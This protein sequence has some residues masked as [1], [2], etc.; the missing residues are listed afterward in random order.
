M[1]P[2]RGK[3]T[4]RFDP[5]SMLTE[6]IFNIETGAVAYVAVRLH[7]GRRPDAF[8]METYEEIESGSD[9]RITFTEARPLCQ[10]RLRDFEVPLRGR[11][12]GK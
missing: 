10:P 4:R 6:T 11:R 3:G 7:E 2:A 5:E 9:V 12:R 1:T 8:F